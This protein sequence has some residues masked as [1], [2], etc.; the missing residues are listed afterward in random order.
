M[1]LYDPSD[2]RALVNARVA[3]LTPSSSYYH[4]ATDQWA[5][6]SIPLIPELDPGPIEHLR[7]FVDDRTVNQRESRNS[8]GDN[9]FVDTT[10]AVRFC[11][12]MRPHDRVTDWD[13]ASKAAMALR[14]Q[15]L[16]DD[17]SGDVTIRPDP[18]VLTRQVYGDVIVVTV[19]VGAL[20]FTATL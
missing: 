15:L 5:E 20:Y 7:F 3:A 17:W 1:A 2:V 18:Q 11:Y 16:A 14:R 6:S 4:Q 8:S 13:G 12:R 9:T 19:Y 10:L